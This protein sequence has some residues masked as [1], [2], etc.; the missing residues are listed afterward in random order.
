[1]KKIFLI[2]DSIRRG[3]DRF[4]AKNLENYANVYF[5]EDNCRFALYTLRHISDW[6]HQ[7]S[8]PDDTDLVHW[9]A[10][11]WDCLTL[12]D[13]GVLTPPEFYYDTIKRV[14]KRIR[15]LF[16]KAK[17]IFATS[18]RVI[19]EGYKH[20]HFVRYNKDI[21]YFNELAI[22]ALEG[23]DTVINDLWALTESCP[24]S[25]Y[26]DMTHL[27]TPEGTE[28]LGNAVLDVICRELSLPGIKGSGHEDYSQVVPFG[29]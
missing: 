3:Y 26:S 28:L 22:K 16:P 15:T 12:Y 17:V 7:Y 24:E 29:I 8:V 27:Y 11:L 2:G 19:E 25:Y 5:T 14:D 9:N 23:T 10:G 21:R 18:T 20:T 4:I 6:K 13:D 1:M